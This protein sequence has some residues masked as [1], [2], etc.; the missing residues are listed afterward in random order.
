MKEHNNIYTAGSMLLPALYKKAQALAIYCRL[1]LGIVS[2]IS[3]L[4][5]LGRMGRKVALAVKDMKL[6]YAAAHPGNHGLLYIG[7]TCHSDK[8]DMR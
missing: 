6:Q 3:L 2:A 1:A 7:A 4:I 5:R 8:N